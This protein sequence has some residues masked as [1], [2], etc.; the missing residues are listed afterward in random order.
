MKEDGNAI[1]VSQ[2]LKG[3][4]PI[5]DL[6]YAEP[7]KGQSGKLGQWS[8]EV[9]EGDVKKIDASLQQTVKINGQEHV[10]LN[11]DA[12]EDVWIVCQYQVVAKV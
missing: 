7:L 3:G 6:P 9:K 10:R 4:S 5:S 12:I 2:F 11:P 1:P 8:L